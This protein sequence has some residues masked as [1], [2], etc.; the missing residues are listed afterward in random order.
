MKRRAIIIGSPLSV[1]SESYLRGVSSDVNNMYKF[2]RSAVG[3]AWKKEEI[4]YLKNPSKEN[5]INTIPRFCQNAD[6]AFVI[7]SG[8]GFMSNGNNYLQINDW[9]TI[10]VNRLNA[11]AYR[12][13]TLIDACRNNYPWEHFEGIGDLGFTFDTRELELARV[14]YNHYIEN[15][16]FGKVSIFSSSPN[17]SSYDTEAGGKYTVSLISSMLKWHKSQSGLLLTVDKAF[18]ASF[19]ELRR[20]EL[21]Q[22]PKHYYEDD[23]EAVNFPIAVNSVLCRKQIIAKQNSKRQSVWF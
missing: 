10:N 5:V 12:Q 4:L 1:G 7:Y 20:T 23:Y 6:I 16:T 14:L 3:G 21:Q 19:I 18:K 9:E 17:Q 22:T 11:H 2:L 8:H 15:S 13:I